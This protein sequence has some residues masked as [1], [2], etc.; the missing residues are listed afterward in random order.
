MNPHFQRHHDQDQRDFSIPKKAYG[1]VERIE[2]G[3]NGRFTVSVDAISSDWMMQES[4]SGN[5]LFDLSDLR[6]LGRAWEAYWSRAIQKVP[7]QPLRF[8]AEP[9]PLENAPLYRIDFHDQSLGPAFFYDD[10]DGDRAAKLISDLE[11]DWYAFEF[12]DVNE[13]SSIPCE[14]YHN[15]FAAPISLFATVTYIDNS[16]VTSAAL[17]KIA[18]LDDLP[19]IET[20]EFA[21][22]LESAKG[23]AFLAAYDVGQGNA[24]ALLNPSSRTDYSPRLYFDVGCGVYANRGTTP[25]GLEFCFKHKPLIVMSHWDSDH[26]M[27]VCA[28]GHPVQVQGLGMSWIAPRQNVTTHHKSFAM[29]IIAKGGSIQIY[30]PMAPLTGIATLSTTERI[31]FTR[32]TRADRNHSGIVLSVEKWI[33]NRWN[34]WV[35]TGDCDYRYF[36]H[37]NVHDAVA[38]VVPH[39]GADPATQRTAAPQATPAA[40]SHYVRAVYSFG[41]GNSQSG[42]QHPTDDAVDIHVNAAW[43]SGAWLNNTPGDAV[44]GADTL[45]T[46]QHNPR[47]NLGG[48]IVGWASRPSLPVSCGC[49]PGCNTPITQN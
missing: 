27:G 16:S 35:L 2:Q 31:R 45:A 17:T 9:S 49:S 7:N 4:K 11:L 28:T 12:Y 6:E 25:P 38:V 13:P 48:C 18:S 34:H 47:K 36:R 42:V 32:G 26:W 43:D 1:Q 19:E 37:L 30:N 15:A 21:V 3:R 40:D 22:A 20:D 39:H 5:S 10:K 23:A 33:G 8:I 46:S 41:H 14:L 44:A 24:N 29:D